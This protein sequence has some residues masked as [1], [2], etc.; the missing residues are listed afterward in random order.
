[1]TFWV[2]GI[3]SELSGRIYIGQTDLLQRRIE[4]HNA[5]K[6]KSTKDQ[7]PWKILAVEIFKS[8]NDARWREN[9]LKKS[10]GQRE[11]WIDEMRSD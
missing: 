5:G 10:K 2:Y 11:K 1:M 9:C 6:V 8:R 3:Q 4:E 7:R